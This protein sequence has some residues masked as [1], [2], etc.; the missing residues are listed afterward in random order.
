VTELVKS[1][2]DSLE[3]SEDQPVIDVFN[4]SAVQAVGGATAAFEVERGQHLA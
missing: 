2:F 4:R 3:N 1:A